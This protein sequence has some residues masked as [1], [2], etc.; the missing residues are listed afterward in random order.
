MLTLE[1]NT[2]YVNGVAIFY[3]VDTHL[4]LEIFNDCLRDMV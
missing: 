2:I 1:N 3:S 4:V